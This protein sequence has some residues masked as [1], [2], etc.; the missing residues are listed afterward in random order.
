MN[1]YLWHQIK[2]CSDNYHENGSVLIQAKTVERAREIGT[3]NYGPMD[4]CGEPDEV[5]MCNS[6][7]EKIWVFPNAG[8]C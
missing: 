4:I 8:C 5:F 3:A 1:A 6:T 2:H 7:E